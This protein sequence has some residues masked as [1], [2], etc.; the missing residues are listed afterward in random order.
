MDEKMAGC[1]KETS[2]RRIEQG[3]ENVLR[4][5]DSLCGVVTEIDSGNMPKVHGEEPEVPSRSISELVKETPEILGEIAE[6]ISGQS[7]R[8]R[9]LLL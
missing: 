2:S 4:A 3:F 8:L 7:S 9:D 1:V 6:K 5:I